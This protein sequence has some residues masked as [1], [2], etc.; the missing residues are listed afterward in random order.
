MMMRNLLLAMAFMQFSFATVL[1]A[2]VVVAPRTDSVVSLHGAVHEDLRILFAESVYVG[3][4][5]L[6]PACLLRFPSGE[7][8]PVRDA[9]T[10]APTINGREFG[11]E[12]P[13]RHFDGT[14]LCQLRF[15]A[16]RIWFSARG[17]GPDAP[18]GFLALV[19][20]G[21]ASGGAAIPSVATVT[22][23]S[24]PDAGSG[25]TSFQCLWTSGAGWQGLALTVPASGIDVRGIEIGP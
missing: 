10:I 22:G 4:N 6:D 12:A 25:T 5:L 14:D 8:G 9:V 3:A 18:S 15:A 24:C 21:S 7:Y 1:R 17:S 19:P 11:I 16:I 13:I 23:G 20:A 2:D